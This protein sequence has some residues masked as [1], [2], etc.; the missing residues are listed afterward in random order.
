MRELRLAK[1]TVRK[2][3]RADSVDELLAAPRAG[4]RS[5]LDR[6][7]PHLH[8]RLVAGHTNMLDLHREITA[9]GYRGSYS[10]LRDYLAPLRA[11]G[12]APPPATVVPKV[13][14]ITSWLL[15]RPTDLDDDEQLQL[16][17]VLTACPHLEAT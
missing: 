7:K 2:F 14:Q 1:E 3:Y 5:I 17:Q 13:R 12:Q 6:F 16:K 15:R 10:A 11:S 8:E 9:Q 4:R